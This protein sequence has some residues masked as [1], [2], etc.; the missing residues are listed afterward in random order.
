M[1][2][3][4]LTIPGAVFFFFFFFKSIFGLLSAMQLGLLLPDLGTS[5]SSFQSFNTY[6]PFLCAQPHAECWRQ[7]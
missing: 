6:R 1:L 5:S 3:E 2:P 7:R 4:L